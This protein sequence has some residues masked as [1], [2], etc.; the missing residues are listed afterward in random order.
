[1]NHN[2]HTKPYV[3]PTITPELGLGDYFAPGK[4]QPSGEEKRTAVSDVVTAI[5]SAIERLEQVVDEENAAL[6]R[7]EPVDLAEIAKR[8][9]HSL[10][11]LTR[12]ARA[13]PPGSDAVLRNRLDTLRDK[14]VQNRDILGLHVAA[15]RE[16]SDLMASVLGEADS[17]GTY[18]MAPRRSASL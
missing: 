3:P 14:L 11:E 7:H 18:E 8:K 12:R 10:L 2:P 13:L 9:S 1:M 16:I 4:R 5:E 15:V 6:G 17:D